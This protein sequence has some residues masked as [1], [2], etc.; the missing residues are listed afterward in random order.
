[1]NIKTLI[2]DDDPIFV[3]MLK[4]LVAKD[5]FYGEPK[6]FSNGQLALDFLKP[7]Y[8]P[9]SQYVIFLDINMPVMNGWEFLEDIREFADPKN[10][11]VFI[12]TS[13]INEADTRAAAGNEYVLEFLTKPIL[14]PKLQHVKEKIIETV[15]SAK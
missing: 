9:S 1:M 10:T 14:G 4:K 7:N 15:K 3:M 12:V 11:L 13:S 5:P 6:D 8:D 2:V